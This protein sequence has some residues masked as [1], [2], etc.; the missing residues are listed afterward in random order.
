M[1]YPELWCNRFNTHVRCEC[2]ECIQARY[3]Q[4]FHFQ[5]DQSLYC[6]TRY[7]K[8]VPVKFLDARKEESNE[9]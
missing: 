8:M 1:N 6:G 2:H 3:K 5:L 7:D 4:S 9:R